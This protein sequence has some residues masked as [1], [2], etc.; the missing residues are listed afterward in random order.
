MRKPWHL[1]FHG[2]TLFTKDCLLHRKQ[3]IGLFQISHLVWYFRYFRLFYKLEKIEFLK[4]GL[5]LRCIDTLLR[6]GYNRPPELRQ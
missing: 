3:K 4:D 2:L 1:P 5:C 6:V